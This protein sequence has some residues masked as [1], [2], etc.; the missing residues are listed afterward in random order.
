MRRTIGALAVVSAL[1]ATPA[2]ADSILVNGSFE[3]GPFVGSHDIDIAA[4]S[5]DVIGWLVTGTGPSAIDYLGTPW[6]VSD[7][8]HA[9]DLDGRN[10]LFSGIQQTFDTVA[11]TVYQVSFDM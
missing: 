5:T 9:V 8:I 6:N 3:V 7:G 10:S 1:A 4:G 11:G 2:A